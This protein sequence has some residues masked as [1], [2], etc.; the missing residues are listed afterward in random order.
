MKQHWKIILG[1]LGVILPS[2]FTYLASRSEST[3]AK[4]RAEVAYV[5]MQETV[6]E[7]Q[8]TTSAQAIEL[9]EIRGQLRGERRNRAEPS[10]PLGKPG[11]L[12]RG[13]GGGVKPEPEVDGDGLPEPAP[14]PPPKAA[15]S[16]SFDDAVQ[17]Y[18]AKK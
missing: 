8:A 1:T 2:L 9:A 15:K 6:K 17:S 13:I 10:I 16:P 4:I 12:G 11:T 3:E 18:K 7:L 14:A 5:S